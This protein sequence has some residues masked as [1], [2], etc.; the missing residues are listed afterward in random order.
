MSFLGAFKS[1][2]PSIAPLNRCETSINSPL[3]VFD[4]LKLTPPGEAGV[5]DFFSGAGVTMMV[6]L[7]VLLGIGL[8]L[9]PWS[10]RAQWS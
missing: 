6:G 5:G 8:T 10:R 3:I 9:R 7:G 4:R 2:S 1:N